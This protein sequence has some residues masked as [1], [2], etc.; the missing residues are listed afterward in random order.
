M[1]ILLTSIVVVLLVADVALPDA[2][3]AQLQK[4]SDGTFLG[5]SPLLGA[6]RFAV[7]ANPYAAGGQPVAVDAQGQAMPADTP[8]PPNLRAKMIWRGSYQG[9]ALVPDGNT[10]VRGRGFSFTLPGSRAVPIGGEYA[11]MLEVE[12]GML[13]GEMQASGALQR[14][15]LSGTVD[16]T[17]CHLVASDGGRS[18][19][20]CSLRFFREHVDQTNAQR[21]RVTYDAQAQILQIANHAVEERQRAIAQATATADAAA[22]AAQSARSGTNGVGGQKA[23][24]VDADIDSTVVSGK[25]LHH[26][27][28]RMSNIDDLGLFLVIHPDGSFTEAAAAEWTAQNQGGSAKA[29][30]DKDFKPGRN[31]LIFFLHN[32]QFM[33]GAG[34]WSFSASLLGDGN[35]IWSAEGGQGGGGVGI[36]YWKAFY[37]T[38]KPNGTFDVEA[39][40]ASASSKVK[41][42][43]EQINA[44]LIASKGTELSSSGLLASAVLSGLAAGQGGGDDSRGCDEHCRLEQAY[45]AQDQREYLKS[46]QRPN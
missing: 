32:K 20:Y 29:S 13:R 37:V 8:I 16:G 5:P 23:D 44:R 17:T 34:K 24:L 28:V 1:K 9:R 42:A 35:A 6:N 36:Q 31:G 18:D 46:Q 41:P 43:I 33:F 26:I 21:Q 27:D 30:L 39:S 40:H 45:D 4:G 7:P 3:H 11:V 25:G 22:A 38:R 12:N 2:T 10:N 14:V 15:T 19:A